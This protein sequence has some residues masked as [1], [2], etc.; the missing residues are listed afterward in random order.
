MKNKEII[1][2]TKEIVVAM[3]QSKYIDGTYSTVNDKISEAIRNVYNTLLEL[4]NKEN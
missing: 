3:I 1:E 4:S 2:C